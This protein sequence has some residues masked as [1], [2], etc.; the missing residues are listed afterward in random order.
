MKHEAITRTRSAVATMSTTTA[1]EVAFTQDR[2]LERTES[3]TERAS[4]AIQV[5]FTQEQMVP[6]SELATTA[7]EAESSSILSISS[8]NNVA[9]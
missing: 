6:K 1:S 3:N 4:T 8:I 7:T 5:G 2:S 9:V